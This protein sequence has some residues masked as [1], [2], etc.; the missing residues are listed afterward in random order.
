[1]AEQ[2][3]LKLHSSTFGANQWDTI[4]SV[5]FTYPDGPSSGLQLRTKLWLQ[6]MRVGCLG[7]ETKYNE[8][9]LKFPVTDD[10]V[11]S[12]QNLLSWMM[13]V[14]NYERSGRG[15]PAFS[16]AEVSDFY[17]AKHN[18]APIYAKNDCPSCEAIRTSIPPYKP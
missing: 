6:N 1:M 13:S 4:F 15:V 16:F 10:V 7:C 9:L 17:T 11:L 12:R 2:K 18:K 14:R 8:A 3:C 5:G